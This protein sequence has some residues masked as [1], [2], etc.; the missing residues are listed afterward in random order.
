LQTLLSAS[1]LRSESG[2]PTATP[3][4]QKRFSSRSGVLRD[5]ALRSESGC[6]AA[7]Q[8]LQK[9]FSS[10]SGVHRDPAFFGAVRS[11][12]FGAA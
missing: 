11:S 3:L 7:T 1:A 9:P 4:L 10:R 6:P 2:H 8:L 5:P 12:R